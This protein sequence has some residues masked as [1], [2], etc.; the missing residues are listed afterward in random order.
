MA[1]KLTNEQFLERLIEIHGNKYSYD[2]TVYENS[3]KKVILI[4]S[5]H[6]DFEISVCNVLSG[7]GCGKCARDKHRL[8]FL[9]PQRIEN[10]KVVHKNKYKYLSNDIVG[11]K[12]IITCD[13]HGDFTQSVHQHEY[14]H[15]CPNC[16]RL[17]R[18]KFKSKICRTCGKE[19]GLNEY[20]PRFKT[21][22]KCL[23]RAHIDTQSRFC[24]KCNKEKTLNQFYK[25]KNDPLGR[26]KECKECKAKKEKPYKKIYR[27]VNKST[28]R[29]KDIVYR[30]DR[31]KKDN[32]YKATL[33]AR[34]VIRK[35][36]SRGGYKK[37][38]RTEHILGCD[39][40]TFKKHIESLF[41]EGMSWQNRSKWHIDH[42]IPISLAQNEQGL[43]KLNHYT[44]L[45][46]LW[47][48]DNIIKSAKVINE[49][50]N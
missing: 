31:S 46:P 23:N 45:Q 25:R 35:S 3:R 26:R 43:L 17:K 8:T 11:G 10:L 6:G 29:K 21:C 20:K 16:A 2:K 47:E 5:K 7:Q 36:I 13:V 48:T 34:Q 28:I 37:S 41:V 15:G 18:V 19:K 4:C 24:T 9:T 32:L 44:N 40:E 50:K 27:Q 38:S 39:Y 22:N 14:G 12:I 1:T 42:I 49:L 30:K 33:V